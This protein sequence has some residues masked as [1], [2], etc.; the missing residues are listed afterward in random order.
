MVRTILSVISGYLVMAIAVMILFAIWFNDPNT[1]PDNTFMLFSLV[2]GFLFATVGGYITTL[3]ADRPDMKSAFA[4]A[5]LAVILGIVNM[6]GAR[7]QEPLW[8]QIL[9]ILLALAG[10]LLGG[11]LRM[12]QL[13]K[14]KENV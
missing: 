3:I 7:G 10:I 8:F 14:I 5:G 1:K 6:I 11:F 2:Y 9:N 13:G 4:L 12:R